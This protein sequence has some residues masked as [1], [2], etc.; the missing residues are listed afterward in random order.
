MR[1]TTDLGTIRNILTVSL[2]LLAGGWYTVATAQLFEV[3]SGSISFDSQA[4]LERIRASSDQL[5][6]LINP[7]TRQFAF[8]IEMNTFEGFNNPLQQVHF[9]ENYMESRLYPE[10]TF[11]GKIIEEIDLSVP[12]DHEVRVKGWLTIHGVKRERILRGTIRRL[13]GDMIEIACQFSVPLMEHDIRIPKVVQQKIA[14]S[15][16]VEVQGQLVPRIQ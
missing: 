2:V 13:P 8:S 5:K 3:A 1:I 7:D 15:I 12:G 9:N 11:T 16:A 10:S 4:P 6:G 14:Q